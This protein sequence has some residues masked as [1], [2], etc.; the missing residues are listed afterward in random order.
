MSEVAL[1]PSAATMVDQVR[2]FRDR[3]SLRRATSSY[4]SAATMTPSKESERWV[5]ETLMA[6]DRLTSL[7]PD[8]DTYGGKATT[9]EAAL[10]A[11]MFMLDA[12]TPADE[13]PQLVPTG[14]GG[15]QLE[16]HTDHVDFEVVFDESGNGVA[17]YRDTLRAIADERPLDEVE[18]AID[19]YLSQF[20]R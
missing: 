9:V 20:P 5:A 12:L 10:S 19:K 15:L 7:E 6:L 3:L 1:R 2:S 8:W 14:D 18:D 11:L 17:F 16:W 4:S 13:V